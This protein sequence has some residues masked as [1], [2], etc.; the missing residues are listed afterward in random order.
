MAKLEIKVGSDLK[1]AAAEVGAAWKKAENGPAEAG[2]D[3]LIS[4]IG[5]RCVRC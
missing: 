5:M 1:T 4:S 2:G 3:G